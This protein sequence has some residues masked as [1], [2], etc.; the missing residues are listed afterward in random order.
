MRAKGIGWGTLI[1]FSVAAACGQSSDGTGNSTAGDQASD[2]AKGGESGAN[3]TPGR[4]GSTAHQTDAGEP[5]AGNDPNDDPTG[6]RD[7][8]DAG[9]EGV[10]GGTA[11]GNGGAG[12]GGGEADHDAGSAGESNAG[13]APATIPVTGPCDIYAEAGTPC[14]AA[15]SMVRRLSSDYSG[16][17]YQ[18][19]SGSSVENTG[20]G[21]E[22]HDIGMTSA[23]LGDAS[24][25]D[26][27]C[28]DT[29]CTVSLL[30]DQSGNGNHLPVAP[31]GLSSG[32]EFASLDDFESIA[33]AGSLTVSGEHVYSLYTEA[34]QG[35]RLAEEG[36]GVPQ[37][38]EAQ[39]IY[40][41]ADGTH[42]GSLCCW[43]FGGGAPDPRSFSEPNALFFGTA[44][45]GTGEG[46]GPWFLA[47]FGA[48]LWAGGSD[49]GDPGW[50]QLGALGPPNAANPSLA[51][52][53]ALGFLKTNTQ[54]WSLRMADAS[55]ATNV[56]T[57][58]VGDTPKPIYNDGGILLGVGN[59]NANNS[60]GTFYEGAMLAGFPPDSAELAV[61]QNIQAVGYGQ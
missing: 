28:K 39:G 30:Y 48:G 21:G 5:P 20:V 49:P 29:I 23:G 32:G 19:R 61:L 16:P 54:Q 17:L 53:F 40:L 6:V 46:E 2:D 56:T 9:P 24:A 25:Q 38:Q 35:Y 26:A 60:W 43:S 52:P 50:G 41:L 22:L 58:Y 14:V 44:F 12:G 36:V 55:A 11:G 34:R 37:G 59:D 31:R 4:A 51:V 13:G 3:D 18:V 8:A 57:A 10:G 7:A 47:D 45:F 15:Y 33:D 1:A 27:V 42:Y